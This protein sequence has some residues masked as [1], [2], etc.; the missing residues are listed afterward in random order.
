MALSNGFF[1][2]HVLESYSDVV[3][4]ENDL[5]NGILNVYGPSLLN[6][7][8]VVRDRF[9]SSL[10]VEFINNKIVVYRDDEIGIFTN[11][12]TFDFHL[13]N[14]QHYKWKKTLERPVMDAPGA[15]YPEHRFLRLYSLKSGLDSPA[16]NK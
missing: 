6:V 5:R 2:D 10:I 16:D 11:E 14:V 8:F 4:L 7:H 15:F 13:T 12:P 9:G 1:C 3:L